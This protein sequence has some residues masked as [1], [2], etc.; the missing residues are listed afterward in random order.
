MQFQVFRIEPRYNITCR[1]RVADIDDAVHDLS[2]DPEAEIRLVAGAHHADEFARRH[3]VF[4]SHALD[5]DRPRGFGNGR[6]RLVVAGR[7]EGKDGQE[8]GCGQ[9]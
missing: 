6:N 8:E 4:E 3:L 7:K 9:H 5:L 2:G 1:D